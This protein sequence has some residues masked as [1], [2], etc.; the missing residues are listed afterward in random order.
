MH[1]LAIGY[2]EETPLNLL[3]DTT[4]YQPCRSHRDVL[5]R[6]HLSN[7]LSQKERDISLLSQVDSTIESE[8]EMQT[9]YEAIHKQIRE[10]NGENIGFCVALFDLEKNLIPNPLL[11]WKWIIAN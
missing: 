5:E 6:I 9:A 1:V 10:A 7:S 3:A 8:A 2:R 4:L 11:L